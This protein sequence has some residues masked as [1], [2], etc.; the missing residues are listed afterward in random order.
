MP[1]PQRM[2]TLGWFRVL[3]IAVIVAFLIALFGLFP[4]RFEFWF[5]SAV[6]FIIVYLIGCLFGGG[7]QRRRPVA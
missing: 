5:E 3:A 2:W 6:W 1:G 7:V 4:G